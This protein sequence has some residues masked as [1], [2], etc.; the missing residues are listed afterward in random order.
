M[1]PGNNLHEVFNSTLGRNSK[2]RPRRSVGEGAL[3]AFQPDRSL[4]RSGWTPNKLPVTLAL[5]RKTSGL[6]LSVEERESSPLNIRQRTIFEGRAAQRLYFEPK[7]RLV[8]ALSGLGLR[9][10]HHFCV[11]SN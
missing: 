4:A 5:L 3:D 2:D 8:I 1:L 11:H 6:L 9:Y 7:R 10:P